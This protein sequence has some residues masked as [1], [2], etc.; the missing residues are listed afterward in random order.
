MIALILDNS[1]RKPEGPQ[2]PK[3]A[4]HESQG[5]GISIIGWKQHH[6]YTVTCGTKVHEPARTSLRC[7]G[8][9]IVLQ[10]GRCNA[11][12]ELGP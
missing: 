6:L 12:R 1:W 9:V 10:V 7:Y 11:T 8:H 2:R 5:A 4:R 3:C